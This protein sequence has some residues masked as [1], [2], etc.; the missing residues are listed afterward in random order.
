MGT[1]NGEFARPVRGAVV[2]Y[3]QQVH[4]VMCDDDDDDDDGQEAAV[5]LLLVRYTLESSGRRVDTCTRS[6]GP[7]SSSSQEA[8]TVVND[9]TGSVVSGHPENKVRDHPA[10]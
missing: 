7:R 8:W 4:L 9:G 5:K 3:A 2:L 10:G 1:L 6:C